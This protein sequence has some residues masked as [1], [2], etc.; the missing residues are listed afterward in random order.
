MTNKKEITTKTE[1]QL[2][3]IVSDDRT[4][5]VHTLLNQAA[6]YCKTWN[7]IE[8]LGLEGD[9]SFDSVAPALSTVKRIKFLRTQ[10]AAEQFNLS[11]A[12]YARLQKKAREI[13]R[14]LSAGYSMGEV[15][16]LL[17]AG[18]G[19][20]AKYDNTDSY[21]NSCT[22]R[23]T[24]GYVEITVS[25]TDLR[26]LELI[27]GVWTRILADNKVKYIN[28]TGKKHTYRPEL[29]D[30]FLFGRS[31]ATTSKE[32]RNLNRRNAIAK[33]RAE[34]KEIADKQAA[35]KAEKVFIGWNDIRKTACESA[36]Q[37]FVKN[38]GL[39]KDFG[40]SAK[41]LVQI[42]EPSQQSFIRNAARI[43][44]QLLQTA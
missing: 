4:K 31:H 9:F 36:S 37:S 15:R 22:W 32:A 19:E 17:I 20:F 35:E 26:E 30:G 5:Y 16:K 42:A 21:A 27:E 38:H 1:K 13:L 33:A 12:E 40:Y 18:K 24:H 11:V 8:T 43:K 7:K 10:K 6:S 41:Y 44:A 14:Q 34:R 2:A 23:P 25:L 29:I 28:E 3:A 39:D